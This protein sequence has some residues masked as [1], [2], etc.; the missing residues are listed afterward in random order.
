LLTSA[1]DQESS[2]LS[3]PPASLS[4]VRLS[5]VAGVGVSEFLL[6]FLPPAPCLGLYHGLAWQ[7]EL[8][9]VVKKT[10]GRFVHLQQK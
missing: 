4:A 1:P 3:P 7:L 6:P 5:A 9:F 10:A 2:P 8:M